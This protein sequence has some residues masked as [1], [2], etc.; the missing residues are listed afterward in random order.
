VRLQPFGVPRTPNTPRNISM[1]PNIENAS[2]PT[3]T[4]SHPMRLL[5]SRLSVGPS[6]TMRGTT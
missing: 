4:D 6:L 5:R 3:P 2:S 1:W